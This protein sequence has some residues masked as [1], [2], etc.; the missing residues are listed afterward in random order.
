MFKCCVWGILLTFFRNDG[1]YRICTLLVNIIIF[2]LFSRWPQSFSVKLII[3]RSDI[4]RFNI[5]I[6]VNYI[7]YVLNDVIL[8]LVILS[9]THYFTSCSYPIIYIYMYVSCF[10]VQLFTNDYFDPNYFYAKINI[11]V[12][13]C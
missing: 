11:F 12:F 10:H 4:T 7:L 13:P 5:Y 1:M 2:F 9:E 6:Y 3:L 8:A